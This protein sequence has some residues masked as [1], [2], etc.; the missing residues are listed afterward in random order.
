VICLLPVGVV[1]LVGHLVAIL[2]SDRLR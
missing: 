2:A 1:T